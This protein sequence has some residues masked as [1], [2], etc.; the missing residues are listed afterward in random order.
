MPCRCDDMGSDYPDDIKS[1][2]NQK[3]ANEASKNRIRLCSAQNL[4]AQLLISMEE[5]GYRPSQILLDKAA[6]HIR[7]LIIHKR[8]EIKADIETTKKSIECV[9]SAVEQIKSLGG[10]PKKSLL[11]RRKKLSD[12]LRGWLEKT[13]ADLL[14]TSSET[15]E[16]LFKKKL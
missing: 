9:D 2:E 15:L 3:A 8:D 5:E 1:V 14:G 4:I 16:K 6:E 11:D 7:L 13:D 12:E 10:K